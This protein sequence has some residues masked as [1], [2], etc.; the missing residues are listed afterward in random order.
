MSDAA[1]TTDWTPDGAALP[2]GPQEGRIYLL[3]TRSLADGQPAYVER[4]RTWPKEARS[5][6]LPLEFAMESGNRQ[7]LSEYS[8]G[9]EFWE[10]ALAFVGPITDVILLA[11]QMILLKAGRDV[12]HS[13]AESLAHPVKVSI[14]EL[15]FDGSALRGVA[16]E[17]TG[18]EVLST[19]K[20]II[21]A[22]K[23]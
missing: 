5:D 16:V 19:I 12:G 18:D 22:A 7:F 17:G 6:G 14:A 15:T 4:Q 2:S 23:K 1:K 13:D 3:P 8:S 20:G 21:K 10:V 9:P 11:V